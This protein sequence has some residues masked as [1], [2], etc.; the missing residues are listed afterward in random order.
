ML[1]V[2]RLRAESPRR[3]AGGPPGNEAAIRSLQRSAPIELPSEDLD[4]LRCSD[5][6]EGR[7]ALPPLYFMLYSAAFAAEL[8]ASDEHRDRYP[9]YFVF[10]SNGGLERIAFDGRAA[11]PWPVAMYDPVAGVKSAV[12]IAQDM[13]S[14]ASAIG[15]EPPEGTG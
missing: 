1:D 13:E 3:W 2:A 10:G 4:L 15:L 14:F 6:G 9:R 7:L 12:I 8:N 11:Q 5:G